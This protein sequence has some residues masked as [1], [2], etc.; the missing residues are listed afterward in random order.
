M[1]QFFRLVYFLKYAKKETAIRIL[2]GLGIVGAQFSQTWFLA[3]MVIAVCEK[4][5][6]KEILLC[7]LAEFLSLF[8][9]ASLI[10][11]QEYFL[12]KYA[13]KV[14][15]E[16]R[17]QILDKIM[18]LG[19][20]FKNDQRTGNLQSLITDGVESLEAFL[21]Q[22]IPQIAVVVFTTIFFTTF[23]CRLDRTVGLLLLFVSAVTVIV[24]HVFM[25]AV[26]DV[27]VLYWK[28]YAQLNAQYIDDMQ[29]M[30][31]L[32]SLGV[33]KKEGK[34]LKAQAIGF[35][36]ESMRNLGISLSDSTLITI[37]ITAGTSISILLSAIHVAQGK[38]SYAILIQVLFLAGEC[39]RPMNDLSVYWHNSYTGLS[40]AEDLL[41]V[42]DY[43]V[44]EKSK[45][46]LQNTGI[47]KKPEIVLQNL[48]FQYEKDG[49]DVL[50]NVDMVFKSGKVTA[51][52]GKSGSGKSTIVNL[53]LGFY[54]TEKN[55]IQIDG[56]TLESFEP[57]YL[58]SQISVVFQD[59]F[60]FYGTVKD[61]I[62]MARPEASDAEIMQAAMSANAHEFI[63][64]LPN[65]YDT[66]VGE[67]G[68]TLSGGERQRIAIARAIL[69]NAPILILDEATSS[70]DCKNEQEIQNALKEAMKDRTTLVIAHR[71][72]TIEDADRI[73]VMQNGCVEGCGTHEELLQKDQ[74]YQNL[75]RAQSYE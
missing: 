59:S 75:V 8:I 34:R 41:Y 44:S 16:I 63:V 69:K 54:E 45:E 48:S 52:A 12:K 66:L 38:I 74:I 10:K 15:N 55:R 6:M 56:K 5:D 17:S 65:G 43:P 67:R 61:N 37:C 1:N 53:L 36:A 47:G 21:T 57:D 73:Y 22:Y 27:M 4:R 18:V 68:A 51:I 29:G 70:V 31:T 9:R 72:T 19:P 2:L 60:L 46:N 62:R 64:N 11:Y 28:E 20:A 3:K 33:S 7:F 14:K 26:S 49:A 30:S 35:A 40:V 39:L 32:K 42:L 13:A 58:R 50:K 24:P 23:M 71:M 25:P